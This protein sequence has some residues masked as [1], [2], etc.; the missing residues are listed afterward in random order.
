LPEEG[1]GRDL[2]EHA[3]IRR[4]LAAYLDNAVSDEDKEEI[5]RHLG[6][7]GGCRGEIA[8]LELTV[9]FLKSLPEV[10]PPSWLAERIMA[11]A[12][13]EAAQKRS[14]WRRLIFPL[15]VKLPIEA[16]A[17]LF[18]CVTGYYL[19]RMISEQPPVARAPEVPQKIKEKAATQAESYPLP[20]STAP[21]PQVG[22]TQRKVEVPQSADL[23][24]PPPAPNGTPIQKEAS[25]HPAKS[26]PARKMVVPELRPTD[27][28]LITDFDKANPV[29]EEKPLRAGKR[30]GKGQAEE[31]LRDTEPP[32]AVSARKEE[33]TLTVADPSAATGAIEEAVSRLGGRINGHSYSGESHLL[34]IRI[35]APNYPRLL[36]RLGRVGTVQERPQIPPGTMGMIDLVIRW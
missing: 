32:A 12:R 19:T 27:E 2:M 18:L 28:G 9:R 36:D 6:R 7:C 25:P 10:E 21:R 14:F 3:E 33:I 22:G 35:N 16:L 5:K 31:A 13:D 4:K 23:P 20:A 26:S 11:N 34:F 24:P 1:V 29:F 8:D 17:M 15:H 30:D